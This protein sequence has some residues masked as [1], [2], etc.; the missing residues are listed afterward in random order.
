MIIAVAETP[1]KIQPATIP[2]VPLVDG[3]GGPSRR[4]EMGGGA[5]PVHRP[6]VQMALPGQSTSFEQ[7]RNW[8]HKTNRPPFLGKPKYAGPGG[9]FLSS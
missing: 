8:K 6:A 4:L 2:A 1:I 5:A 7:V 3:R 9:W